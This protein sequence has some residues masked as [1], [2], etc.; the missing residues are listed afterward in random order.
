VSSRKPAPPANFIFKG[1]VQKL[2][3]ATMQNVPVDDRTAVV[4]VDH[5]VESPKAMAGYN[6]QN[7]TVRLAG[8][9]KMMTG[10]QLL[11]HAQGWI[12]GDGIAV[13]A[14]S[15]EPIKPKHAALLNR[16]GDPVE[17][18]R[19]RELRQRITSADT[20][21]SGVVASVRLLADAQD[22]KK[23]GSSRKPAAESPR[24]GRANEHDPRWR[25]A[26]IRVDDVRKGARQKKQVVIR[27]PASKDARWYKAPKL[28]PGQRGLFI[29]HKVGDAEPEVYTAL[30]PHDFQPADQPGGIKELIE[31]APQNKSVNAATKG[32]KTGKRAKASGLTILLVNL[33]PR[34]LSGENNQDSEPSLAVNPANPMQMA[35]SAITPDPGEGPLGPI[36]VS[37]DGGET[38]TLNAVIPGA[39]PG[40][41]ILD[42]TLQFGVKTNVLYAGIL[43]PEPPGHANTHMNILRTKDLASA[44]QMALLFDGANVDEPY[45]MAATVAAGVGAG[46]DRLYVG[47]NDFNE[48]DGR[49]ATISQCLDVTGSSPKF[50]SLSIEWRKTAQQDGPPVRPAIHPDGTV[51]AVFQSWRTGTRADIVVVRDDHGGSGATPFTDLLDP[52][53]GKPGLRVVKNTRF[54]FSGYLGHQRTGGDVAM[55]I[56]P[57]NSD[58]VFVAY[59]DNQGS[60]YMLHLLRSTTRGETWS[61]MRT[62]RNALNPALAVNRDGK[63]GFLY[64]QLKGAGAAQRWMTQ[65]EIIAKG[66]RQ[67]FVLAMMATDL[68]DYKF[69]PYLG[70][71]EHLTAVGQDFYGIFSSN[72]TPKLANFPNGI[73]YQ[74]N[75]D[76]T[77]GKLFDLDNVTPVASSIDPFFFKVTL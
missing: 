57:T 31:A 74:R 55:T 72:N 48:P 66:A 67:R 19:Q 54:N 52:D 36:F 27:F 68:N 70:D 51:Y 13:Q 77:T 47:N 22:L 64:Q 6:G 26:V 1:T 46:K 50:K 11:F 49:T 60:D 61:E 7:I 10:Q 41:G 28:R 45:V 56:D 63:L 18:N 69:D 37:L 42:V 75:A 40:H 38:W 3:A 73:R 5:T 33:I 21:V 23:R 20:V 8:R 62:I 24:T 76:F 43:R 12:F 16:G 59:N 17:H 44:A 65:F 35:G 14:L 2:K 15:Q 4:R 32:A 34:S 39:T 29:L 58:N 71:Y 53:D 25:Y 30:H 9:R